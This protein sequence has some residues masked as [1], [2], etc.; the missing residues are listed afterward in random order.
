MT[1]RASAVTTRAVWTRVLS[2]SLILALLA[3]CSWFENQLERVRSAGE[4]VMIT[5]TGPTTYYETPDGPA[6]FEYDLAKAFADHLRVK[7]RVIAMPHRNELLLRLSRQEA[8]FTAGL[9]TVEAGPAPVRFT[10]PYQTISQMVVTRHGKTVP[11]EV[12]DLL[13]RDIE[14]RKD[15]RPVRH[16]L[17]LREKYPALRWN[18]TEDK[19]VLELLQMVWEGLLDVTITDS[20]AIAV[21][22]QYFPE[23]RIAF[24]LGEPE[25]LAWAFRGGKDDS[26]HAEAQRFLAQI[27]K[28]G[29][30]AQLLDRYY[31]P[32]GLANPV[33]LAVYQFRIQNRL[34]PYQ[35]LFQ[36]AGKGHR[37]DWRLL[38]ALAYQ[39]SYWDPAAVSPTGVRGMMMLTEETAREMGVKNRIHAGQSIQGGARYFRKTLDRLPGTVTEPD[40]TWMALAA[41]NVGM[42]HL[43]DARIITQ[44]RGGDPNRW[45]DVKQSLP[46]LANPRWAAQAK[47]GYARGQEP[48]L[49]VNRIR[50]YYD[51][52]VKIDEEKRARGRTEALKIHAPAL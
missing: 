19:T 52:L 27:K 9:T 31:G 33:N 36:K 50:T 14:V 4:L 44:K 24:T 42:N 32:A 49:F 11:G 6:G 7:L 35:T 3:G 13:G 46:L 22:R 45:N 30:L 5:H 12:K 18:E 26:L 40:R 39:E 1:R 34:P 48:V 20:H 23:L 16:L 37:L 15:G 8:D 21:N 17:L 2:G 43:E 29:E 10:D 38:A 51:V 28:S 47:F 41:Y 25:G